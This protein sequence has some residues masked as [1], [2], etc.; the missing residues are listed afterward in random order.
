MLYVIAYVFLLT[1]FLLKARLQKLRHPAQAS[2]Y[3][4]R[5]WQRS[6]ETKDI[7][8]IN[9]NNTNLYCYRPV[10]TQPGIS[11]RGNYMSA[12]NDVNK[13]KFPSGRTVEQL[14]KDAK[15]LSKERSI[16]HT[17]ALDIIAQ[18]NDA[19]VGWKYG[20]EI[21]TH[22]CPLLVE[23]GGPISKLN[24]KKFLS[25]TKEEYLNQV[26]AIPRMFKD[27]KTSNKMKFKLEDYLN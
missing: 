18:E 10:R 12:M 27:H 22:K 9:F 1:V 15:R 4:A 6:L 5:G 3:P 24:M 23:N 26:K 11:I 20:L 7:H 19:N 14:K 16:P 13:I 2:R 8:N 25:F 21:L 17:E